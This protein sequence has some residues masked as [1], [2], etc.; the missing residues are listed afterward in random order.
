[1]R[2]KPTAHQI[3]RWRPRVSESVIESV[4]TLNPGDRYYRNLF[5]NAGYNPDSEVFQ[6]LFTQGLLE[7][8]ENDTFADTGQVVYKRSISFTL[9]GA[10]YALQCVTDR[11]NEL[12]AVKKG[13]VAEIARLSIEQTTEEY[14][15]NYEHDSDVIIS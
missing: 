1:M 2:E 11:L 13:L 15:T 14:R 10:E 5:K 6:M 8:P 3:P 7:Y 12:R 9:E 4:A